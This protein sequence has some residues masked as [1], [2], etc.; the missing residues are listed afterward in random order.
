MN[1]HLT[2]KF[3]FEKLIAK[4]NFFKFTSSAEYCFVV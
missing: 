4:Q 1:Y 3:K 2:V